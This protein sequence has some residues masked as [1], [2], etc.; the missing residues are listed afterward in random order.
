MKD[1]NLNCYTGY[2]SLSLF[3]VFILLLINS[4]HQ[5]VKCKQNLMQNFYLQGMPYSISMKMHVCPHV[6][7]K[8]CS[9]ADEVKISHLWNKHTEPLVQ[10]YSEDV[11]ANI[12]SILRS[13]FRLM[14][15][16]PEE[17][18]LKYVVPKEVPFLYKHCYT[19]RGYSATKRDIAL[20]KE[21]KT[22]FHK[23]LKLRIWKPKKPKRRIKIYGELQKENVHFYASRTSCN[24]GIDVF[25]RDFVVVNQEKTQHCIG[26]HDKFMDFRIKDF[27]SLLPSVKNTLN[28]MVDMKKSFY[29][30]LC[31]AHSHQFFDLKEKEVIISQK[32][33]NNVLRQKMDYFKFMHIIFIEF[34]NELLQYQGCYETDGRVF[35]FPIR[36]FLDK[37]LK[38]IPLIKRCL[39]SLDDKKNFYKNC[40][41]ICEKYR[42]YTFSPFFDGDVELL[43]RINVSLFSF[44][45]KVMR[46]S[47]LEEKRKNKI[48]RDFNI[49]KKKQKSAIAKELVLPE[50]IDGL[51][52]EPLLLE[53]LNPNHMITNKKY[54]FKKDDMVR[55]IGHP[56]G[57][58]YQV[59]YRT[60]QEKKFMQAHTKYIK[61]LV[62]KEKDKFK[63]M[64]FIKARRKKGYWE[65]PLKAKFKLP[66]KKPVVTLAGNVD[67][68]STHKFEEHLGTHSYPQRSLFLTRSNEEQPDEML[69]KMTINDDEA[70]EMLK[71]FGYKAPQEREL[72]LSL[73]DNNPAN[74]KK[75]KLNKKNK[76]SVHRRVYN[77]FNKRA[78]SEVKNRENLKKQTIKED[79]KVKPKKLKKGDII[80][81]SP[82]DKK[83]ARTKET[84]YQDFYSKPLEHAQRKRMPVKKKV[85]PPTIKV[86][87]PNEI[88][89]RIT[90]KID[91]EDFEYKFEK[92]G[93]DPLHNIELVNFKYNITRLIEMRYK[94]PEK[95]VATTVHQYLSIDKQFLK[96]FNKDI[97][98]DI[99]VYEDVN[100][101]MMEV[102]RMKQFRKKLMMYEPNPVLLHKINKDI[103]DLQKKAAENNARKQVVKKAM[104]ARRNRKGHTDLNVNKHYDHHHHHDLYF[105][106]TFHGI[107]DMFTHI[108]GS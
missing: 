48:F 17:M 23:F 33:C 76:E 59:G 40:W 77:I 20:S 58:K 25:H 47:T 78:A 41:M 57:E 65:P 43:R 100:E 9:I 53:P 5:L 64:A 56:H 52:I 86:E 62:K 90:D 34:A 3:L 80:V 89:E 10:R 61:G 15:L 12:N 21:F 101:V 45:R 68:L 97:E 18:I 83:K 55:L 54:Y 8:C 84:K 105:N 44:H 38:R 26:I 51:L 72:S 36:T 60:D 49:S 75:R 92:V 88:F 79:G 11:V 71:S 2:K 46:A 42:Y 1:N 85:Y 82:P 66:L 31:D 95:L 81:K 104:K 93:L 22:G 103:K 24:S 69:K 74:K 73:T 16:D 50:N 70:E 99:D 35:Q 102:N 32:F 27:I 67:R 39:T 106:D 14:K 108:F 91:I 29:C 13:F 28:F 37:Y 4:T 6:H 98:K 30:N 63:K 7:D 107:A 19:R 87:N 96:E 94:L